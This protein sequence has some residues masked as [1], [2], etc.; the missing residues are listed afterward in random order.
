M[1]IFCLNTGLLLQHSKKWIDH[2]KTFQAKFLK[3][4]NNKKSKTKK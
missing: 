3:I 4:G 1:A 2:T